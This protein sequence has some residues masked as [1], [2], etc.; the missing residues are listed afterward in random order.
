MREEKK[1]EHSIEEE[2]EWR[3][4]VLRRTARTC[5][6]EAKRLEREKSAVAKMDPLEDKEGLADV[7]RK[8]DEVMEWRFVDELGRV[9]L[10][11]DMLAQNITVREL[12]FI[13]ACIMHAISGQKGG[14]R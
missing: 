8:V 13:R 3:I 4:R 7:L 5:A 11:S 6:A 14:G 10:D 1:N 9:E 12:R 2:M